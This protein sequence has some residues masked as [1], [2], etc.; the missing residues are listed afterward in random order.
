MSATKIEWCD[1]TINPIVGCSKCSPGCEHC[2][3]ERRAVILTKNTIPQISGKY[4]GVVDE[5][6][7]WTGRVR[8]SVTNSHRNDAPHRV[9]G[10]GKRVFIGSMGDMFHP[11]V[12]WDALD[13][14]FASILA[15]HIF[16]NGHRHIFCL[17]TKRVDRMAEYFA[18]GPDVLLRRWG[19][20]GGGWLYVGDGDGETFSEYAEGQTIPQPG[21]EQHPN[22]LH[23]YLWPLP[24]IWLGVTV[25]TPAELW[26]IDE[27]K[28]IPAA[29]RFVSFEPLLADMGD[30]SPYFGV[31]KPIYRGDDRSG[32]LDYEPYIH[33]CICGGETGLGARPMHLDWVRSLRDQC[34]RAGVPFFLKSLGEWSETESPLPGDVWLMP[35][36]G[37]TQPW[38]LETQGAP[39][40]RWGEHADVVM[41]RVGKRNSGRL[42]DGREWN[43][44]PS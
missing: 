40:C 19:K 25:C 38:S 11:N 3:A 4:A 5:Y 21:H 16:T 39:V 44:V 43:E 41:R 26:K 6:G 10:F 31:E 36:S 37:L 22:L 30:I 35:E 32:F 12:E 15:D 42:L 33:W 27:L 14:I 28:K 29:K 24:N 17:L 2:Y 1:H 7:K 18:P 13:E 34:V 9:P 20:A 23:E 8:Y